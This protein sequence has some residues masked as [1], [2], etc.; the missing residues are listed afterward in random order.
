MTGVLHTARINAIEVIVSSD[1][2][3]KMVSFKLT[4]NHLFTLSLRVS[5]KLRLKIFVI[6]NPVGRTLLYKQVTV[7]LECHLGSLVSVAT[8]PLSPWCSVSVERGL[9]LTDCRL[10]F[11]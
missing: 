3:I 8:T 11:G 10:Q 9:T 5:E 6:Q 7:K 2:L 1:K 4:Y